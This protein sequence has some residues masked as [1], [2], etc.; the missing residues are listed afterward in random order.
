M[1]S[2]SSILAQGMNHKKKH[3]VRH[4]ILTYYSFLYLLFML[5]T[6]M[7]PYVFFAKDMFGC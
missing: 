6:H 7:F 4:G 5:S 3:E 2:L 1:A